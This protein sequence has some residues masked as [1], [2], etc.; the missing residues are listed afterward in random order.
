MHWIVIVFVAENVVDVDVVVV[1]SQYNKN[2]PS[3]KDIMY[4]RC[5]PKKKIAQKVTLAHIRGRGV[6]E[7]GPMSPSEQ[8]FLNKWQNSFKICKGDLNG[9]EFNHHSM[10][11]SYRSIP[12]TPPAGVHWTVIVFVA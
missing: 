2:F 5:L 10:H 1:V 7:N 12:V 11:T 3:L 6:N 4:K 8:F 9:D